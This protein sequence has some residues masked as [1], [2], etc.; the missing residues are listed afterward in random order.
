LLD[1]NI[2]LRWIK[3]DDRDYQLVTSAVEAMLLADAVL[4][5]TS[6]NVGEF[7]NTCTRALDRNGYDDPRPQCKT[8][9]LLN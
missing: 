8:T 3:P 6:Q 4:C 1:T 5:Y 9:R 7:W 2:L